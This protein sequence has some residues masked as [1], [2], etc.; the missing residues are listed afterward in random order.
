VAVGVAMGCMV[1][2][3]CSGELI[4]PVIP[5]VEP[6]VV[7]PVIP[8]VAPVVAIPVI[9]VD[10]PVVVEVEV[11][12]GGDRTMVMGWLAGV[13]ENAKLMLAGLITPTSVI[14]VDGGPPGIGDGDKAPGIAAG[15][16]TDPEAALV[17]AG[18]ELVAAELA[19]AAG[20]AEAETDGGSAILRKALATLRR[21]APCS[22]FLIHWAAPG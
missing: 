2:R 9:P 1:M 11:V 21:F 19:L 20:L 8:V 3:S 13:G 16:E 6:M 10:E 22:T 12:F 7:V 4:M 5:V 14:G 15:M 18:A 17:A